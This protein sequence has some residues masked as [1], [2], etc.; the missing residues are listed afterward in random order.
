M[1]GPAGNGGNGPVLFSLHRHW[2]LWEMIKLHAM[3]IYTVAEM[4]ANASTIEVSN[5][6]PK[7]IMEL[8]QTAQTACHNLNLRISKRHIQ[9][10]IK[11]HIGFREIRWDQQ[12]AAGGEEADKA[13][14][15]MERTLL[16]IDAFRANL[17]RELESV[18]VFFS[19]EEM[20]SK[21]YDNHYWMD[22][23]EVEIRVSFPSAIDD[24]DEAGKCLALDRGTA[25][26]MHLMRVMEAGLKVLAGVLGVTQQNDWGSYL[27]KIDDELKKRM[28]T[29]GAR[30]PDEAFYS[31]VYFGFDAVRR[32]WRNPTMH[33]AVSYTPERAE[34][35]AGS[36]RS[37][38]RHLAA[39]LHE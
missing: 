34:E 1:I 26:V 29:S 25:C 38:M 36:V 22:D 39:R 11:Y 20:V 4:L 10:I 17:R 31:E 27:R 33:V 5:V 19:D 2:S 23:D 21:Y 9:E 24:V 35:I 18:A 6:T 14:L 37:F 12:L 15:E 3:D 30:S 8:V 13:R 16:E 32:A 7:M 28:N